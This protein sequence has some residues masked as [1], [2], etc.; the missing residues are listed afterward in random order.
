MEGKALALTTAF[1]FGLNPVVLKL[2]FARQG[3]SDTALLVGL[4]VTVP[5]YLLVAPL[6]GGLSFA[7]L[8]VPALVGFIL[9]GLFGSGIGRRW[10][11]I[12]ID[13]IGASPAAAIKN[14]APVVTTCLAALV[15][16]EHVG[17]TQWLAIA[18]IVVGITL[19]TWQNG[20]GVGRLLDIGI[21]AAFGA[22]ISYGIR[23]LFLEF[24]LDHADVPLTAAFIGA[25]AALVYAGTLT[26]PS[27]LRGDIRQP[28][29][30]LFMAAG[31][32]QAFGFLALTFGLA[33]DDVSVVYPVTS[34]APLF[35]LI[36]TG[37]LLRN[38][39]SLTARIVAGALA[40]VGG[41]VW[42]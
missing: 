23:P 6:L 25:V 28:A 27:R 30:V 10:M 35:T 11:Y 22:A 16:D 40:V 32:L 34:A 5:I 9:G 24:G 8:T 37:L 33:A 4:A 14:S 21:L 29:L 36:F 38:I 1:L 41:V 31:V 18:A 13:R 19:L 17:L 3:R 15:L 7:Q 20:A 42:I 12:A 39:E 2:G 26:P